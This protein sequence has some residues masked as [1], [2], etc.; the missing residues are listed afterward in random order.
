MCSTVIDCRSKH[1]S[2]CETSASYTVGTIR[3]EPLR[4]QVCHSYTPKEHTQTNI[5]MHKLTPKCT[6]IHS[7]AQTHTHKRARTCESV[8]LSV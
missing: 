1:S 2:M 4:I 8:C 3:C 5:K 6:N 7:D